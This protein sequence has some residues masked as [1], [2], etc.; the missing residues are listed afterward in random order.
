MRPENLEA[1]ASP[2]GARRVRWQVR[3]NLHFSVSP[4]SPPGVCAD[5]RGR[6]HRQCPFGSTFR[7]MGAI[8][9]VMSRLL[10][11]VVVLAAAKTVALAVSVSLIN[12]PYAAEPDRLVIQ[13]QR[14]PHGGSNAK[15]GD[16]PM[17]RCMAAWDPAT[18]MSKRERKETC[19]RTV[20]E[21]P[22]LF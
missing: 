16:T 7:N 20:K 10:R 17:G 15:A 21:Y 1:P 19:A 2:L 18:Q 8:M 3:A 14:S 9:T 11:L 6:A 12:L 4:R 22:S 5:Y 13:A